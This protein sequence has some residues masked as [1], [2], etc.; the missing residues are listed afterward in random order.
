[1]ADGSSADGTAAQLHTCNST[2]AQRRSYS[3]TTHDVVN[4]AADKCLDVTGNNSADG[5]WSCTGA[6]NQK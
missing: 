3:A 5:I 1:M 2:V 4:T 6:A